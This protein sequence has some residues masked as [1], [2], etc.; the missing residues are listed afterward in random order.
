MDYTH[1]I[2]RRARGLRQ[3]ATAATQPATLRGGAVV[4]TYWWVG[5]PNFGDDMTPWLLPQYGVL[6][7][8]RRAAEARLVG[9]GSILEHMP[10]HF[11]GAIWGSGLMDDRPYPLPKAKLL[12]VRGR[13]TAERIGAVEGVALGDPGLLV[14]RR[15]RRPAP[16]WDVGLIPH[17][18]HQSNEAFLALADTRGLRVRVIDVRRTA[19]RT[20]RDIGA[21]AA[22]VTTSLHGLITADAFGIP[23][24]W[25]GLEPPL[26][27]GAFKFLDY[28]SVVTP[29]S[30]RFVAFD[31]RMTLPE[32]LA[33]AVV[34]P[35]ET[36]ESASDAL[37]AAIG[38]LPQALGE[39]PRFP[40]G[41]P[42]VV[43]GSTGSG[44]R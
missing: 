26:T 24:L 19:A 32:L 13:L 43:A 22:V 27:G 12:A 33:F 41:I 18:S 16:R 1:P 11:D 40:L 34:A 31:E 6:P 15:M 35:R 23:A 20:V 14:A 39:L 8:H 25:T 17:L 21:C 4:G 3:I 2:R 9:A 30:S 38:R 5:L 10:P 36:V 44:F 29:D 37:E 28:E 42:Q 7:V